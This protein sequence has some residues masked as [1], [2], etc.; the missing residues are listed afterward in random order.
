VRCSNCNTEL[1]HI[2]GCPRCLLYNAAVAATRAAAAVIARGRYSKAE[3]AYMN[4]YGVLA[5]VDGVCDFVGG[6][7]ETA[8]FMALIKAALAVDGFWTPGSKDRNPGLRVISEAL[9][10]VPPPKPVKVRKAAK[11]RRRKS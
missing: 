7:W 10:Q 1:R 3:D 5:W 2:D 8:P 6:P 11:K 9:K 4:E